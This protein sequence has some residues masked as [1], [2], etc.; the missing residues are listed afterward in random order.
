MGEKIGERI[1]F[2]DSF[3]DFFA[4]GGHA[5]YVWSAYG[6]AAVLIVGNIFA[7]IIKRKQIITQQARRLRREEK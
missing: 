2:F 4:M 1:M 6:I 3:S 5:L 7:P